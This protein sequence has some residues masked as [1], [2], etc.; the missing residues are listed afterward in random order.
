ME[1]MF[2][3]TAFETKHTHTH[4]KCVLAFKTNFK[5]LSLRNTVADLILYSLQE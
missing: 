1:E 5:R 3:N 4:Q 2:A